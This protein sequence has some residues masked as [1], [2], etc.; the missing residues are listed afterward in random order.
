MSS[1]LH[2]SIFLP[3]PPPLPPPVHLISGEILEEAAHKWVFL[4]AQ[5]KT[6][7]VDVTS[8]PFVRERKATMDLLGGSLR[9]KTATLL[10]KG[11]DN[12]DV[13]DIRYR[14]DIELA[15]TDGIH[16]DIDIDMTLT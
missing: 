2:S 13:T 8:L 6:G 3:S 9:K 4:Q 11:L 1:N 10:T 7:K 14:L 5:L 16:V 12:D 15:L